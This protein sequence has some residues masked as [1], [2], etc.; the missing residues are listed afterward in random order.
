MARRLSAIV[1][2]AFIGVAAISSSG[3]GTHYVHE[4]DDRHYLYHGQERR[5]IGQQG[6]LY[7]KSYRLP[8]LDFRY[9]YESDYPILKKDQ[10]DL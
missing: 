9:S 2:T 1:A 4:S 7:N 6:L 5:Y 8:F 10:D 3:C